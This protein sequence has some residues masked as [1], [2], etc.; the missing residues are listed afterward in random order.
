MTTQAPVTPPDHELW[1]DA[2]TRRRPAG[3][4]HGIDVASQRA[5]DLDERCLTFLEG[6]CARGDN[7]HPTALDLACGRGGQALRMA[8][9]G[10]R[11]TAVDQYDHGADLQRAAAARRVGQPP[12][13]ASADV[14][15]LPEALPGAPFDAIVCQRAL[16][17]LPYGEAV[18]AVRSWVRYLKPGGRLFLSASGLTS[19][20]GQGYAHGDR[21]V[22][23]RFAPLAPAM[24]ERHDI[25]APVCLYEASDL[26]A[27]LHVAGFGVAEVFRSPFGN[28]KAVAFV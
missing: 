5:D 15:A 22:T 8:A 26:V 21:P 13:F 2:H 12:V 28:V 17:Y 3:D 18:T 25:R 19:E 9:C 11:V 27:L 10:A 6:R 16:H 14:R 23:E 20:L 4:G 7:E 1:L 24:A